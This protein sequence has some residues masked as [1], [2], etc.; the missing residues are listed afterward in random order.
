MNN[1][2]IGIQ[3]ENLA[4][5][6]LEKNGFIIRARNFRSRQ[7]EIDIIGLHSGALVFVEVKYRANVSAGLPEE[8]VNL[9]KQKKICRTADYY[10]MLYKYSDDSPVRYD[11]IGINKKEGETQIRW[12]QNAF[13]HIFL[14]R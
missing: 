14:R 12:Y 7:G 5:E 1:R 4:C 3:Y 11:I 6:Y 10:R 9:I 2:E 8:A 13:P